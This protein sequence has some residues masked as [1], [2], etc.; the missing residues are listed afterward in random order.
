MVFHERF[1]VGL[2]E[3]ASSA[4]IRPDLGICARYISLDVLIFLL[5]RKIADR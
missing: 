1:S 2:G 5:G 4:V 3:R